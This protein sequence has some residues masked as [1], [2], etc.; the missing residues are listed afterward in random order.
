M[1]P[2]ALFSNCS[3]PQLSSRI[4]EAKAWTDLKDRAVFHQHCSALRVSRRGVEKDAWG[5]S[6]DQHI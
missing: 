1:L 2:R 3:L 6:Q 4:Y 5:R